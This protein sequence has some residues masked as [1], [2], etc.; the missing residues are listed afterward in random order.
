MLDPENQSMK[1]IV[2]KSKLCSAEQLEEVI[3]EHIRTGRPLKDIIVDFQLASEEQLLAE[4]AG[5]M[6]VDF[7]DLSDI[8]LDQS[9]VDLVSSD[10]VRSLG[11][12]PL[13]FDG[14]T[15]TAVPRNPLNYQ[16]ADELHFV[17]GRPIS[18]VVAMEAEVD[19]LIERYYPIDMD[20][21]HELLN[22]MEQERGIRLDGDMEQAANEAPIVKFVEAVLYQAIRDKA[23]D[24]HFEPFETDFKIR[25]RI[26]GA[27]YEMVP[28]PKSLA[29]PV[30]SRVKIISGLNIS[31]RRKPQDGRIQLKVNGKPVDMRVSTLPT[32]HGESVV[33]RVL[34]RSAVNLDLDV[35][36]I[37]ENVLAKIRQMISMPNGIF[38]ITGPTGSGKTTTLYSALKELNKVEVKILTAED[39]VE[40]DLDGIVQLP[41]DD[42]VKMTFDRALR[43][44]LRQDPDIIMLGETRDIE[45]ASM[46]VQASLTGHLVFTTLHTNDAAGAITRLVDMGVE[47]YLITSSL[48][49]VLGQR[50]IRRVC[51]HCKT[52][53]T[54]SDDDL[55]LLGL[56]R[57]DIGDNKFYYGRGCKV[58]NNTGYKGRKAITELLEMNTKIGELVLQS[59]PT[60][61]INDKAR[62]LGMETM[63]EDGVRAILNG[64][65]TMEEVLKYT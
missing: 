48:V 53:F 59:A 25:Y 3:N 52:A 60:I 23:S 42:A 7:V 14:Y 61:V 22:E 65:T 47:P 28:P 27:L 43:A 36:G 38:I 46:A 40:Y 12:V 64:E 62:E 63:R 49:G 2:L 18:L 31:E 16:V 5:Q 39:P 10:V 1:D 26:D 45:S 54:P 29:V 55:A 30:I 41:I 37:N 50:L 44:F 19:A 13:D 15:V 56:S 8:E 33:L 58:C 35:L 21:V 24:I 32:Q 51:P 17:L 6:N 4:I 11:V 34:D 57:E 9:V 20:S